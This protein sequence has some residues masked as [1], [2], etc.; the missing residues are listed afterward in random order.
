MSPC[1]VGGKVAKQYWGE[2]NKI[3]I[4]IIISLGRQG[5]DVA[6]ALNFGSHRHVSLGYKLGQPPLGKAI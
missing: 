6:Q 5:E 1:L 3:I 4:I 2:D